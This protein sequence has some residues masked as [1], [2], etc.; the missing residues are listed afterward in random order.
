MKDGALYRMWFSH[1]G[2]SYRIGYAES[3]DGLSWT[4]KDEDAG[5]TTSRDGWDSEMVAYPWVGDIAGRRRMLY[6]GNNYGFTGIG[7][8]ILDQS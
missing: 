5:I 3:N 6:N 2:A 7:Q 1:R 8:A 4:R